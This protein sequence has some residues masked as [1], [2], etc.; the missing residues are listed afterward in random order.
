MRVQTLL[1]ESKFVNCGMWDRNKEIGSWL[2]WKRA[3]GLRGGLDAWLG[4]FMVSSELKIWKITEFSVWTWKLCSDFWKLF[5]CLRTFWRVRIFKRNCW[6]YFNELKILKLLRKIL[7]K[8]HIL[9]ACKFLCKP[10]TSL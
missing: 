2:M 3:G 9:K 6:Y 7:K 4:C 8:A 10:W 5:I 1:F